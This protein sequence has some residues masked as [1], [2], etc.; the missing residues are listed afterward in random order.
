MAYSATSIL[1]DGC[2]PAPCPSWNING[3]TPASIKAADVRGLF[4][5]SWAQGSLYGGVST[6][7]A[8]RAVPLDGILL[9][10]DVP[11]CDIDSSVKCSLG[12]L[13]SRVPLLQT[14]LWLFHTS[15]CFLHLTGTL[16]DRKPMTLTGSLHLTVL[17]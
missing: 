2:W 15:F 8:S 11:N 3:Y 10:N 17:D 16:G 13:V 4:G 7:L 12:S 5:E 9:V 6:L 1:G 14:L